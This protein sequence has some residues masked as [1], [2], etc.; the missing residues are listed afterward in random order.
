[1]EYNRIHRLK[2]QHSCRQLTAL[3]GKNWDFV[4][5]HKLKMYRPLTFDRR[6]YI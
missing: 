6:Y 1:M 4:S 2:V 3:K 5:P